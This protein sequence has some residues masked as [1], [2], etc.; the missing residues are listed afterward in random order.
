M[1]Q[2]FKRTFG[3]INNHPLASRSLFKAYCKFFVW[4]I[5]SS[6]TKDLIVMPFIAGVSFWVKKGLT[7]ATGNIYTGL[8]E[9]EDMAF[10]LHYL[11]EGD[12]FC[13]VGSNVGSY[14]LLASGVRKADTIAFEPIETTF[15]IL[16]KNIALNNLQTL[17]TPINK[18]VGAKTDK[19]FF[20]NN[21]DTTNHVV[22]KN[23]NLSNEINVVPLDGYFRDNKTIL[24][25]IDVE[26]FEFEVLKGAS[27]FLESDNLK[28]IIIEL[29]GSGN[30]Y[31]ID[32]KMIHEMLIS[33]LFIPYAYNPF[34]RQLTELKTFGNLNTIY[35]RDL[36]NVEEKLKSAE[37]FN[38][39]SKVI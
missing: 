27:K 36:A 15:S 14:S 16:E 9:F 8:H 33:N 31:G 18:G 17:I 11:N 28:A 34:K 20:S 6:L 23:E 37:P 7:G 3:F 22:N 35:V 19:L 25:K 2:S 4:Q 30:R 39:F 13:D 32:E 12:L 10:L 1:I 29:N 26:G 38:V 5:K 21:Q 24:L